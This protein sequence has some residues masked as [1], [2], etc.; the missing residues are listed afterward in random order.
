MADGRAVDGGVCSD[1]S[2]DIRAAARRT[3]A[4]VLRRLQCHR[5]TAAVK[6]A[7]VKLPGFRMPLKAH[8]PAAV[9]R[10]GCSSL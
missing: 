9:A 1:D 3:R 2:R 7:L 10:S 5:R 8:P 4:T 6:A